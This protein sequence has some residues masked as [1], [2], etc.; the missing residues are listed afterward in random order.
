MT[1]IKKKNINPTNTKAVDYFIYNKQNDTI[2]LSSNTKRCLNLS[3]LETC[4]LQTIKYSILS[5]D[6]PVFM[7]HINKWLSGDTKDII[8]VSF[9]DGQGKLRKVQ[10]KGHARYDSNNK[11][12]SIYGAFI[13][14]V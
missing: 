11:V 14:L 6:I 4:I 2:R 10:I 12:S 1:Q 8:Q 13:K 7:K 9:T 3:K 5:S